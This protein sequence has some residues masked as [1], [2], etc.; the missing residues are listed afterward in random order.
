[1]II[2][3]ANCKKFCQNTN[4]KYRDGDLK[5]ILLP[6]LQNADS[7]IHCHFRFRGS[8]LSPEYISVPFNLGSFNFL[9]VLI[10][11]TWW[12]LKEKRNQ[13]KIWVK[14]FVFCYFCLILKFSML[15]LTLESNLF[16][17]TFFSQQEPF[18][19]CQNYSF[20]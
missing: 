3:V 6:V 12:V 18:W 10:I 17:C 15:S 9:G 20:F 13:F 2:T 16:Y 8:E 1:M 7:F 11:S 19:D 5:K 4:H 14:K